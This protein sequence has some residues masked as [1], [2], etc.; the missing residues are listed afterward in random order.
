MS[1]KEQCPICYG[2]LEVIDC[3]PC[4]DCGHMPEE[5]DHL[6]QGQ[7]DYK[8]YEVYHGLRLQLC[9]FCD[10]DFGSYKPEYLGF[11][12]GRGIGWENFAFVAEV[13]SPTVEK[14]KFC[15]EC[16][17]RLKF[18]TFLRDMRELAGKE[19]S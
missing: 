14:D 17:R 11:K 13:H 1:L 18:L 5:I 3:A 15:P 7:H 8:I 2:P 10:V 12:H 4:D 19:V 16:D 9:D 6:H